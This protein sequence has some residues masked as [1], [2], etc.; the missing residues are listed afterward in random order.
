MT[1]DPMQLLHKLIQAE[2]D[3]CKSEIQNRST[4]SARARRQAALKR[5]L[6]IILGRSPTPEEIESTVDW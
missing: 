1:T 6:P 2:D 5:V 4:R 3:L